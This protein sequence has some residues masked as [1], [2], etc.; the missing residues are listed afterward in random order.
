MITTERL[1]DSINGYGVDIAG[2]EDTIWAPYFMNGTE[3]LPEGSK[4]S[5]SGGGKVSPEQFHELA[6]L[7]LKWVEDTGAMST[8]ENVRRALVD[9]SLP[10]TMRYRGGVDCS[11]FAYFALKNSG[12]NLEHDL[13]VTKAH[14]EAALG[15]YGKDIAFYK[16][17]DLRDQATEN[18]LSV[19]QFSKEL[20]GD[21]AEPH[22]N[23]SVATFVNSS[24]LVQQGTEPGD[25]VV[26]RITSQ[27]NAP[28]HIALIESVDENGGLSIA[29]STRVAWD[30]G[31][32]GVTRQ[33][34]D[35]VA[36]LQSCF[37]VEYDSTEIRRLRVLQ[38]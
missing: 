29:H 10:E 16:Q 11:G 17:K 9:G 15:K 36:N 26:C 28:K 2:V 23:V 33:S 3:S 19:A 35:T 4:V 5:V 14:L 37:N 13:F 1:R 6:G 38:D 25:L 7:A 21:Q 8:S 34:V 18:V 12:V 20:F 30:E 22:K 31:L 27:G 32:G 24:E